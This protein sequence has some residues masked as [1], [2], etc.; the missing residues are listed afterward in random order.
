MKQLRLEQS[1]W[2]LDEGSL[3]GRPGGFGSVHPGT[4]EDGAPVA[5]K[6]LRSDIGDATHRELDFARV[7]R[8]RDT[9]H[10]IPILDFGRDAGS[11]RVCLVMPRAEINLRDRLEA[12]GAITEAEAI[13]VLVEIARGLLEVD[14]WVHR[15]LKPEN[16]LRYN[17]RWHVA[18]FG[19][20]RLAEANTSFRTVKGALSPRY[21]APEQWDGQRATHATDVY[22][23]GCIG[24]E[25]LSGR[26]L[27]SG[28]DMADYAEQHRVST[29]LITAGS[30]RIRSLLLR[31]VAKPALARPQTENVLTQLASIQARPSGSGLGAAALGEASALIADATARQE[32]AQAEAEARRRQ[33][34][35]LSA[36]AFT[37]MSSIAERLCAEIKEHAPQAK[38]REAGIR[39]SRS[40]EVELGAGSL[41][42]TAGHLADIP[43]NAF[44]QCGWDVVCGDLIFVKTSRF[45]RSSSLWYANI[46][47]GSYCWVEVAYQSLT[48]NPSRI[49][50]HLPPG[51]NA[52]LAAAHVMH[53]WS[54]AHA[55]REIA[56]EEQMDSFCQRWMDLL[57]KAAVGNLAR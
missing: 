22:A 51:R 11:D 12:A 20:A 36:Y 35:E 47:N 29:P 15:D 32:A 4:A 55:P 10:V 9:Q 31:M 42:I 23:L 6:I 26:P 2:M 52:D 27:Y 21:A 34:T 19:I 7:F 33:R 17:N 16:V 41:V 8:G 57:S 53:T 49:P 5:I 3:L 56:T 30:P 18:D 13:E 37:E 28:P 14:D 38:I 45:E 44:A 50:R 1:V 46:G 39:R 25:L 48:G 54:L 40:F 24:A 43:L